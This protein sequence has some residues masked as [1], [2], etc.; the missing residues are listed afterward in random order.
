VSKFILQTPH[1]DPAKIPD[2]DIVG[3]T[4]IMIQCF[5]K[6]REFIRI[7]Y[8]LSH[9][10]TAELGEGALVAW[11]GAA[12]VPAARATRGLLHARRAAALLAAPRAPL[13]RARCT[14]RTH[15]HA[16]LRRSLCRRSHP[17]A[18]AARQGPARR[19]RRQAPRDAVP[20]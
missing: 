14:S 2:D 13:T 18:G 16:C 20:H 11:G 5:Y 15:T 12:H 10:Y 8:Y 4:V 1:P 3:A 19:A 17:Q 9:E 6:N 7:G